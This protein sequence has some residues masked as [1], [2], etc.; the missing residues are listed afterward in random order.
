[1]DPKDVYGVKDM[2]DWLDLDKTALSN[3]HKLGLP[4][5]RIGRGRYVYHAPTV[6]AWLAARQGE[7]EAEE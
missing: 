1:M 6:A 7:P 4:A 5:I 2:L 3:L